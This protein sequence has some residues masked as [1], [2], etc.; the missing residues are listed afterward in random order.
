MTFLARFHSDCGECGWRIKPGDLAQYDAHG[1][2][3]HVVCPENTGLREV[4]LVCPECFI[5]KSAS[6]ACGCEES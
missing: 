2:V 5:E 1:D 4:G 6:G 3:R